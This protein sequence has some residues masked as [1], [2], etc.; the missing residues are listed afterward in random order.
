VVLYEKKA[1][2]EENKKEQIIRW[3]RNRRR[4]NRITKWGRKEEKR[5]SGIR[6][7]KIKR[8]RRRN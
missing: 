4:S 2:E 3:R 6:Q 7:R 1:E 8:G 5:K